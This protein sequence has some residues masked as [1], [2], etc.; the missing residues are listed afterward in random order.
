MYAGHSLKSP[1]RLRLAVE[2]LELS[3]GD[4]VEDSVRH[5]LGLD[6]VPEIDKDLI[7]QNLC[8]VPITEVC[9]NGDIIWGKVGNLAQSSFA[10][11]IKC[12]LSQCERYFREEKF[13]ALREWW[14]SKTHAF[15]VIMK[16][17]EDRCATPCLHDVVTHLQGL[18]YELRTSSSSSVPG[19]DS[20]VR[21]Q[22]IFIKCHGERQDTSKEV[23]LT[24]RL[25]EQHELT[26]KSEERAFVLE[27]EVRSL[28][29]KHASMAADIAAAQKVQAS[30][31]QEFENRIASLKAELESIANKAAA[32][33]IEQEQKQF[34]NKLAQ[35]DN[36]L[37]Q[38]VR[39]LEAAEADRDRAQR[40]LRAAQRLSWSS[41]G[42]SSSS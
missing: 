22:H 24:K 23:E 6:A 12:M 39:D 3:S 26:K 7:V 2:D 38:M 31:K 36:E 40:T 41:G 34:E 20:L 35:K 28:R 33:A 32:N 27:E 11:R 30:Q 5:G 18:G 4:L 25:E 37:Q 29:T 15:W 8:M 42:L 1:I 16:S 10:D 9:Q 13:G 19:D 21:S 17:G 14:L